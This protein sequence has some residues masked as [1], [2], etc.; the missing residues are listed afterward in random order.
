MIKI[1]IVFLHS[2]TF[3]P[4][5]KNMTEYLPVIYDCRAP[6]MIRIR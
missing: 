3:F 2:L 1:V 6:S 5:R 4:G